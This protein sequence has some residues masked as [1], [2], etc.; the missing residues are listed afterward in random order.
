MNCIGVKFDLGEGGEDL[1]YFYLE[2]NGDNLFVKIKQV[3]L[4]CFGVIVEYLN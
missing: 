1:V 2:L 3:V 4:G